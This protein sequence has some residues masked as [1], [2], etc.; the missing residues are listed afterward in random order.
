MKPVTPKNMITLAGTIIKILQNHECFDEET[1]VYVLDPDNPD[2]GIVFNCMKKDE[3]RFPD[4]T[5]VPVQRGIRPERWADYA[6][7][8]TVTITFEGLLY[9]I[10]N[11]MSHPSHET[12]FADLAEAIKPYGLYADQGYPWSLSLY[13][14]L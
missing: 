12:F 13:P 5:K 14:D 4:G 6:N 8:E 1:N 11:D 2:C 9:E 3:Y 7:T 10:V